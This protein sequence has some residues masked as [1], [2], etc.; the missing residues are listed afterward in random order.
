M[1]AEAEIA[2]KAPTEG[3]KRGVHFQKS[4]P[5]VRIGVL[6]AGSI[7]GELAM[8]GVSPIRSATI[9]AQTLCAM[10]EIPQEKAL[11]MLDRFPDAQNHFAN[12]IVQHLE[13]T[14]P[15]RIL[16][17]QL[18]DNFDRKFRMLLGLYC[19][20]KAYFPGQRICRDGHYGD[21]MFIVNQGKA[22]LEKKGVNV[23]TYAAGSHF[24]SALMLG[25]GKIY[26]GTLRALQTCHILIISRSCYMQ[27]LEQYPSMHASQE[28]KKTEKLAQE[29][30]RE[31]IQRTSARKLIWKRY[32][33]QLLDS[34]NADAAKLTETELL[35]RALSCWSDRVKSIVNNRRRHERERDHYRQMMEQWLQ[36]RQLARE[37]LDQKLAEQSP[38][39]AR[40]KTV[41]AGHGEDRKKLEKVLED[42]PTP[43]P[44]PHYRLR[45]FGVLHEATTWPATGAPLLPLLEKKQLPNGRAILPSLNPDAYLRATFQADGE[46]NGTIREGL[47][48]NRVHPGGELSDDFAEYL[49]FE[50]NEALKEESDT[51][52]PSEDG[53]ADAVLPKLGA[54]HRLPSMR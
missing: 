16:S 38:G 52:I 51:D 15:A 49:N 31:A 40:P 43:R 22:T 48:A 5:L 35:E 33:F 27:V 28:L 37:Y 1:D 26:L 4:S 50:V 25:I 53:E 19:E 10:W 14:V 42:W 39:Y 9:E 20:R 30:L 24:G 18:F 2:A 13:R 29:E 47:T 17:T 7:S 36:K 32:Q 41:T 23:K 12:I 44:S 46:F 21:R 3:R 6:T 34:Q 45:V 54:T 8:L 11:V